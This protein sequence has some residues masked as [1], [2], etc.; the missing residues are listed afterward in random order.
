MAVLDERQSIGWRFVADSEEGIK[1][2]KRT[3]K[4]GNPQKSL[5][6]SGGEPRLQQKYADD[7][8]IGD[9]FEYLMKNSASESSKMVTFFNNLRFDQYHIG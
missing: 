5:L 3:V 7:D 4:V 8:F 2:G 6:F 1:L 9:T